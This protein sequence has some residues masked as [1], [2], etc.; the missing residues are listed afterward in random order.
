M[1]DILTADKFENILSERST[2]I[3]IRTENQLMR[4]I[5]KELKSTIRKKKLTS[6]SAPAIG[7]QKR[8]FCIN[9]NDVEIKTFI[10]PVITKASGMQLAKE[11]C[12]SIPDKR[13][14][15]P[16]NTGLYIVYQSPNGKIE[17][18]ELI[19]LAAIICQH[20]IDHL[21]GLLLSDIGQEIPDTYD[22]F[23]DEQKQEFISEYL[24]EL[25]MLN[26][27]YQEEIKTD[28]ELKQIFDAASFM[29]SVYKGETKLDTDEEVTDVLG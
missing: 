29:E 16:R 10:N 23:S 2:E 17:Q 13:Y 27:S 11:T 9:F 14:I 20:E 1:K 21:D 8:I 18:R 19:G 5:V 12:T 28:S 7:Y 25:D 6:L 4:E 15:R 24:D 3:D 26:K 22:D